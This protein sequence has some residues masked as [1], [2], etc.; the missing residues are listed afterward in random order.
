MSFNINQYEGSINA[1]E[2]K[3]VICFLLFQFAHVKQTTNTLYFYELKIDRNVYHLEAENTVF[4]LWAAQSISQTVIR[5]PPV[6]KSPGLAVYCVD[7]WTPFKTYW[8]L[9]DLNGNSEF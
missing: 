9:N 4:T 6:S 5:W 2:N 8:S 3:D 1:P 7:W